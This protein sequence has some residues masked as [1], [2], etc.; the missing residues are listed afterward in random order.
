MSG[1]VPAPAAAG[2]LFRLA[3]G[4]AVPGRVPTASAGWCRTTGRPAAR[5]PDRRRRQRH[6]RT[7]T[8]RTIRAAPCRSR[9][10]PSLPRKTGPSLRSPTARSIARAVRGASGMVA[11]LPPLRVMVSVRWPRSV[12]SAS[13]FAPVASETATRSLRAVRSAHARPPGRDRRRPAS[14]RAH[15]GPNRWHATHS[16][17]GD[18]ARALPASGRAGLPRPR[19]CKKPAMV[20]SRRVRWPGPRP[21]PPG[22]GRSTRCRRG[23]PGTTGDG[24]AGTMR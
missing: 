18:G 17:A 20:Q 24:A 1:S 15:C 19:T 6:R 16:P 13:M 8:R 14:R 12:P 10:R 11:T 7:P 23:G 22:R 2:W 4:S 21:L 9:R 3:A 5:R